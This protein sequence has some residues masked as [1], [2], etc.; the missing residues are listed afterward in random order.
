MDV[1][2]VYSTI[3]CVR[4]FCDTIERFLDEDK[5]LQFHV[6]VIGVKDAHK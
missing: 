6:E 5:N 3:K 2:G 1:K 4:L